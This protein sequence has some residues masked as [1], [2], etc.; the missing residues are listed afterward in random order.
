MGYEPL[1]YLIAARL[2]RFSRRPARRAGEQ[3]NVFAGNP[4]AG[5]SLGGPD[6]E[7]R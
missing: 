4:I 3:R 5:E 6:C 7:G 1:L 2:T